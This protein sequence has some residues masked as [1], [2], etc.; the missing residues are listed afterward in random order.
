MAQSAIFSFHSG[1]RRFAH[2]MVGVINEA[3]I[4]LVAIGDVQETGPALNPLPELSK[5]LLRAVTQDKLENTGSLCIHDSPE[6][7]FVFL[8]PTKVWSSSS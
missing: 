7:N 8:A 3:G 4:H 2:E 6:P 5:R 1:H